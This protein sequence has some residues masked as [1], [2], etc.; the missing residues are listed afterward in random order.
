ME[1]GRRLQDSNVENTVSAEGFPIHRI[2]EGYYYA[3]V[4]QLTLSCK[5]MGMSIT[6]LLSLFAGLDAAALVKVFVESL[7]N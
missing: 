6:N 4:W 3:V 5:Q 2:L 7:V 1:T